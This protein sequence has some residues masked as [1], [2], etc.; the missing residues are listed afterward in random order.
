MLTL[1]G[2][3]NSQADGG[4]LDPSTPDG[5]LAHIMQF[6]DQSMQYSIQAEVNGLGSESLTLQNNSHDGL[7]IES[8]G[9]YAFSRPVVSGGAYNVVVLQQPATRFCT[10]ENA[11]GF[12]SS[13]VVVNV[14]CA[15]S[16]YFIGGNISGLNGSIMLQNNGSDDLVRN[17]NGAFQ[18]STPVAHGAG[19]TVSVAQH[20]VGQT[21]TVSNGSGTATATINSVSVS[22]QA[23]KYSISGSVASLNGSI[24]LKNNGAD[25]IT[26]N[27]NGSFSFPAMID[28]GTTYAVTISAQPAGQVCSVSNGSGTAFNDVTNIQITCINNQYTIGGRI[29]GWLGGTQTL[30]LN[31][32][33]PINLSGNGNFSFSNSLPHGSSYNITLTQTPAGLS[34]CIVMNA[35][36][37]V[38]AAN[39]TNILVTCPMVYASGKIWNRCLFGQQWNADAADCT[40][41]G[42]AADNYGAVTLQYCS[43]NANH[44][45]TSGTTSE[46]DVNGYIPYQFF[47]NGGMSL[48]D[49]GLDSEAY[50]ACK[51]MNSSG[52]TYGKTTWTMPIRDTLKATVLCSAG[53]VAPLAN[54]TECNAGSTAPTL[55]S[56]YFPNSVGA[57]TWSLSS[58]DATTAWAVHFGSGLAG[59]A[60]KTTRKYVRCVASP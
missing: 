11:V 29:T 28:H 36:G 49:G 20:P 57:D 15:T 1:V 26:L 50:T 31:G 42:S 23:R 54:N 37:T 4:A 5:L 44:C 16:A 40:G 34:R 30:Y 35:G 24:E 12:A 3:L 21:C 59:T 25:P 38:N 45:N 60:T 39:V 17:S 10:P 2:C 53:P 14:L 56:A 19:Y 41:T 22:C 33:N 13:D 51:S 27:T 43:V 46:A 48:F 55:N 8:D 52:G 47:Y 7:T 58:R 6:S 18:F 32:A 9:L